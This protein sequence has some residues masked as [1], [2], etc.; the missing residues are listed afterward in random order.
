[1]LEYW[2]GIERADSEARGSRRREFFDRVFGDVRVVPVDAEIGR[3]GARVWAE[4]EQR[5]QT[6]PVLD[7]LIGATALTRG[8]ALVTRDVRHFGRVSGLEL[9]EVG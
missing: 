5:G 7:L 8:W 9:I 1:M 3:T 6:I 4:L 2:H